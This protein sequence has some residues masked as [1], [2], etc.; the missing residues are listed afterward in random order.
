METINYC[1][2]TYKVF[3]LK[4]YGTTF[5]IFFVKDAY[6]LG[7]TLAVRVMDIEDGYVEDFAVATV[8]LDTPDE[9][10]NFAYADTNNCG[11]LLDFVRSNGL[12]KETG[13]SAPSGWCVYPLL[14]WLPEK[15]ESYGSAA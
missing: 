5:R 14:E 6:R 13:R 12:A 9:K 7:N 8:K 4:V 10:N 11:W 1:G 3:K 15:F 2:K